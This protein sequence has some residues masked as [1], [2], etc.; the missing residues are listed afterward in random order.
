MKSL[1]FIIIAIVFLAVGF[2]MGQSFQP[3]GL[4]TTNQPSDQVTL[5]PATYTLAFGENEITEFQN[6]ALKGEQ[7]VL[8]LL[9]QLTAQNNIVLE[10]KDY[11]NL[12]TLVETIGGKKNGQENKYWQ[13]WVNGQMPQVGAGQYQLTGGETVEWKFTEFKEEAL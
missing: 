9:K 10:T 5:S 3:A 6:V 4:V 1:K 11:E 8:D 12:G 13:Y 7:T 2:F